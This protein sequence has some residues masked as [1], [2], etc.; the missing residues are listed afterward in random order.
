MYELRN[1]FGGDCNKDMDI[2]NAGSTWVGL[3][4]GIVIGVLITWWVYNRQKKISVKQ[5][6]LL[7]HIADLEE[8]NK[9]MLNKIL[10]LEE[11]IEAMLAKKK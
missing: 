10:S 4:A 7:N 3:V 8:R 6:E 11:K 9:T 5:D 2:S 1:I